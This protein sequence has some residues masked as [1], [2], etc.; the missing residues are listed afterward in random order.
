M[1][2]GIDGLPLTTAKTGI[3]HYTFELAQALARIEPSGQF[4]IVYPSNYKA[5]G[6]AELSS[7]PVPSNLKLNRV[8]VGS[9]GR[10]WWSVGLPRYISRSELELFHGTNYDIPLRRRCAT[11][12]TVHDLS[13]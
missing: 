1:H 6:F 5:F 7:E 13:Q 3:G 9:L 2:I 8:Q 11:V 10:H 4:E 12:L